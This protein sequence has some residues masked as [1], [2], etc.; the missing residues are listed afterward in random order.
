M[1][2]Y[3]R[4]IC[5]MGQRDDGWWIRFYVQTNSSTYTLAR[6]VSSYTS[7]MNYIYKVVDLITFIFGRII[8]HD[9]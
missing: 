7:G 8:G 1:S 5:G 2:K 9:V 6:T 3:L 4:W